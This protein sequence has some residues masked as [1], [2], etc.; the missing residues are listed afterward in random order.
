MPIDRVSL[1]DLEAKLR[2]ACS[3][4]G[5]CVPDINVGDPPFQLMY[6]PEALADVIAEALAFR[7]M[8]YPVRQKPEGRV[9]YRPLVSGYGSGITLPE[10]SQA[11]STLIAPAQP[12]RT[13]E[14]ERYSATLDEIYESIRAFRASLAPRPSPMPG[15]ERLP[16]GGADEKGFS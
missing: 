3:E 1:L 8:G 15:T 10:M 14:M 9:E 13:P 11:V 5:V 4:I 6:D 16:S 2:R 12:G 7:Q